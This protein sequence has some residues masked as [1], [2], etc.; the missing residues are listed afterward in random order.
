M[1][2]QIFILRGIYKM[3]KKIINI[4]KEE[5]INKCP[6]CGG[7]LVLRKGSRGEFFGC[8]NYPKCRYTK[9]KN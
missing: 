5:M 9:N 7:D 4:K 3:L 6:L 1:Y 2:L 8:S